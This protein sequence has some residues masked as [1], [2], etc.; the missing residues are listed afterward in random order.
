M[1]K[2]ILLL[3]LLG[4]ITFLQAGPISQLYLIAGRDAKGMVVQ[5]TQVLRTWALPHAYEYAVAVQD[6][7]KTM[8]DN[9]SYNGSEYSLTGTRL[10]TI[11][12]TGSPDGLY[13]DGTTDGTYNYALDYKYG[14]VYRFNLDWQNPQLMF[15]LG[16]SYSYLGITYD[17]TNHSLWISGFYNS[18]SRVI[19][20]YTMQGTL[21]STF[22]SQTGYNGCLALDYADNTLWVFDRDGTKTFYQ[23]SKTGQLLSS[24]YAKR[25][26]FVSTER[27][28]AV[29]LVYSAR[30]VGQ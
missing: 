16:E 26:W 6:T 17:P 3:F 20:N 21:L 8:G 12:T 22:N 28:A 15:S 9:P 19:A 14:R 29:M 25:M 30:S 1:K 27:I 10:Q 7:V 11:T 2:R 13:Y 24:Q 18:V 4:I 23:Y 5:G